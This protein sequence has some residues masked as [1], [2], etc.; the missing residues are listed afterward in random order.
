R[1]STRGNSD[2]HFLVLGSGFFVLGSGSG[3]SEPRTRTKNPEPRTQNQEPELHVH[4][5]LESPPHQPRSRPFSRRHAVP[6]HRACRLR[7]TLPAEKRALRSLGSRTPCPPALPRWTH[8]RFV[9]GPWSA[10]TDHASA[11]R[12][13]TRSVGRRPPVAGIVVDA[14]RRTGVRVAPT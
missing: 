3:F 11:R 9:R 14:R 6:S 10:W 12:L 2:G 1:G 5:I 13:I 7:R 4:P 8:R